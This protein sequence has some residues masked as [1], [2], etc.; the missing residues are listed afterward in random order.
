MSR[1]SPIQVAFNSGEL[2]PL[3]EG[4]V[5]IPKYASGCK[6]LEN[7]IPLIQGP[8]V[9]RAGFRYLGEVIDSTKKSWFVPFQFNTQQAY[10]L[11]F[12]D[13][14]MRI[15]L[16]HGRLT[17]FSVPGGT[18][19]FWD[20][21]TNYVNGKSV[22]YVSGGSIYWTARRDNVGT[23][24]DISPNDWYPWPDLG[25]GNYVFEIKTP[26]SAADLID[27]DGRFN[28]RFVESADVMYL[29]HPNYAPRKLSRIGGVDWAL[30]TVNFVGG[31]FKDENIT[32]ITVYSDVDTGAVTLTASAALFN[33]NDVGSL[34]KLSQKTIVDITSWQ[35]QS[36]TSQNDVRRSDGKNYKA[37]SPN[38]I[39]PIVRLTGSNKPVHTLG[40]V[41]DGPDTQRGSAYVPPGGGAAVTA[42]D[43]VQWQYLDPGYGIILITGFTSPT[44][45]TGTVVPV[46][47]ASSTARLPSNCVGAGN[48]SLRWNKA[49]ISVTEG[50]PTQVSFFRERLVLARDQLIWQSVAGDYENFSPVDG[51]NL[52]TTDSAIT[53]QLNS[54][55]INKIRWLEVSNS[56]VEA[57]IAGTAGAEFSIRSQT[58]NLPYGP[59]NITGA[60]GSALGCANARPVHVGSV[61]LFIQATG[62][63]LRDISYD[64][65]ANS[66]NSVDQSILAQHIPQ[67]GLNHIVFQQEPYS[68]IWS[69][70]Q[71]GALVCMTYSREQYP[72]APHGGWHRHPVGGGGLVESISVIPAPDLSKDELWAIIRY[73]I[74]GVTKR[75]ICYMDKEYAPGVDPRDVFYLDAGGTASTLPVAGAGGFLTVPIGALTNAATGIIFDSTLPAF[76]PGYEGREIHVRYSTTDSEGVVTFATGKAVITQ[77]NSLT[78]VVC[79]I[80]SPFPAAAV[81]PFGG[82][83]ITLKSV[84]GLSYLEGMTVDVLADGAVH[85]QCVVTG[86]VITLQQP[87]SKVQVGLACPARLKTMRFN[88]GAQDGT[89]QSKLSR[90][91]K[92]GVRLQDTLGLQFG[93]DFG[94]T[95][96]VLDDADFRTGSDL[97][98]NPP[99]YFSG[100]KELDFAGEWSKR[101]WIALEQPYPLP[102]TILAIMPQQLTSDKG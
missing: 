43:G 30:A 11:E 58:D 73:T 38:V 89:S 27:A 70:R 26:W 81:V 56:S 78:E 95:A 20:I 40:A 52:I 94:P 86:G 3:L 36:V 6:T 59:D 69:V 64:F 42:E 85:P 82:W 55:Q 80:N 10:Q 35:P 34:F 87:A 54:P 45:V 15:W 46:S 72:E 68:L 48:A 53:S 57:L 5:D 7:F 29:C 28:L 97:M 71:D 77:Y 31:P 93:T 33:A 96:P 65:Y 32:A 21:A 79:T 24:P 76:Y 51:S 1:A 61:L 74:G 83:T 23:Q 41:W 13:N 44:V 67:V 99:P 37:I 39:A 9:R 2:S 14:K 49:A 47:T 101:P 25:G 16:N 22:V 75:Y 19:L 92:P 4:R 60:Q 90:I 18:L 12:G 50:W 63:K 102:A 98:D 100:D 62:T 84:S 88:T 17:P 8:A 91:V 66:Y